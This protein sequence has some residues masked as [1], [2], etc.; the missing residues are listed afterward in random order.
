M[1]FLVKNYFL[2]LPNI[3]FCVG[4]RIIAPRSWVLLRPPRGVLSFLWEMSSLRHVRLYV[5]PQSVLGK[6]AEVQRQRFPELHIWH[7]R[8]EVTQRGPQ[9]GRGGPGGGLPLPPRSRSHCTAPVFSL[10]AAGTAPVPGPRGLGSQNL[11]S[12]L[13]PRA[14]RPP[15]F[16]RNSE[17]WRGCPSAE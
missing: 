17:W 2:P 4:N 6:I 9:C 5:R 7:L 13:L 16:S 12:C 8:G 15:R 10:W 3:G 11:Q 1:E 14:V